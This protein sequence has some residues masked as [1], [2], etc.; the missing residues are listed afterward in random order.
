MDANLLLN[1]V[2]K[3]FP[4][5]SR[6]DRL[7]LSRVTNRTVST[8]RPVVEVLEDR[9]TPSNFIVTDLADTAGP[10]GM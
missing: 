6:R 5:R 9:I 2:K 8:W 7:R 1:C 10:P 3:L 4:S